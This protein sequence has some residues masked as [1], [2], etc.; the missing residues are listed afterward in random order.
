MTGFGTFLL[1]RRLLNDTICALFAGLL[2]TLEH[3]GSVARLWSFGIGPRRRV[4]DLFARLDRLRRAAER[5]RLLA[6]AASYA[7]LAMSAAY[8]MVFAVFP[9]VLFVVWNAVESARKG[10]VFAVG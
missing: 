7:I 10:M 3:A 1:A 2:A 6:S 8:F 5:R 4:S 9:A